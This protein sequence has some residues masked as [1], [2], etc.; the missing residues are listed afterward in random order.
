MWKSISPA[1]FPNLLPYQMWIK[2]DQKISKAS[3]TPVYL[4]RQYFPSNL[5]D[6]LSTRPFLINLEKLWIMYQI[7]KAL[8]QSHEQGVVHGGLN[9]IV[10]TI[11][12]THSYNY[13]GDIKPENILT[14]S[15]NWAVLTDFAPQK[16]VAIP[17]DDTATFHYFFDSMS[18]RRCYIAPER[19]YTSGRKLKSAKA[20]ASLDV[21]DE[22]ESKTPPYPPP[23]MDKKGEE[24]LTPAMDVFSLGCTFAEV[25]LDGECLIDLPSMLQYL[26]LCREKKEGEPNICL[27][28]DDSPALSTLNRI[29]D[30]RIRKTIS[31]MTQ[32]APG[33]RLSVSS[34][35]KILEEKGVFPS[36][37]ST[38]L[39]DLFIKLHWHGTTPDDRVNIICENYRAIIMDIADCMDEDGA[40]FF[41]SVLKFL[42][43]GDPSAAADM[44]IDRAD[45][46]NSSVGPS[47][48]STHIAE[49]FHHLRTSKILD[50]PDAPP[51]PLY[52]TKIDI[53]G[54]NEFHGRKD[55]GNNSQVADEMLRNVKKTL[56]EGDTNQS[57]APLSLGRLINEFEKLLIPKH[58][59]NRDVKD[60]YGDEKENQ[61]NAP[62]RKE[63][64]ESV[65]VDEDTKLFNHSKIS[66]R[67]S[68]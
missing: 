63:Y 47:A 31:L 28:D 60:G 5:Y 62:R 39:Y 8:E 25:L 37:F 13:I 59:S 7:M 44:R 24:T 19:F 33:D 6:R 66:Q 38:V 49:H 11:F 18:R 20:S 16:P 34:Y 52:S 26:S 27:S 21:V 53:P 32:Y 45:E 15:W 46:L 42:H 56:R 67:R 3:L 29:K 61:D 58:A 9:D 10:T 64:D 22:D 65:I 35:R 12:F 4:V 1:D 57:T 36:F 43:R 54:A 14:T 2:S 50:G 55:S 30:P 51:R 17:D 40:R 68:K 41:T 23:S 48:V